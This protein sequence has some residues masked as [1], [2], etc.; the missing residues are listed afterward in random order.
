[1]N[2]C[3]PEHMITA[4][5]GARLWPPVVLICCLHATDTRFMKEN[6]T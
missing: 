1:M 4:E 3:L 5:V 6:L 2:C